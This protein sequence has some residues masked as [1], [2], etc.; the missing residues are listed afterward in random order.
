MCLHLSSQL[1][2][3]VNFFFLFILIMHAKV[4]AQ[5]YKSLSRDSSNLKTVNWFWQSIALS[6]VFHSQ[7]FRTLNGIIFQGYREFLKWLPFKVFW[8]V[9]KSR[10]L[11]MKSDVIRPRTYNQIW[12][13]FSLQK[14]RS[15]QP[16]IAPL[17]KIARDDKT[18]EKICSC[19]LINKEP[20]WKRHHRSHAH[21]T[22]LDLMWSKL[23]M[24]HGTEPNVADLVLIPTRL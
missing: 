11:I 22:C 23:A 3:T 20:F 6:R 19:F 18:L 8:V 12:H 5:Q 16:L 1:L 21:Q 14:W 15:L 24:Y 9:A 17:R 4:V 7:I 2:Q 10:T 13:H